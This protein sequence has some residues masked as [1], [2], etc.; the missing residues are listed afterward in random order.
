MPPEPSRQARRALSTASAAWRAIRK[1][2]LAKEPYC[3]TCRRKGIWRLANQVD[4][5]DG[6][7][8][9]DAPTNYQSLC[10]PCHSRKTAR[11]DGGFGNRKRRAST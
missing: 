4:H 11:E 5:I 7:A 1:E 10:G 2:Q 3:R 6:D 9:N 8:S